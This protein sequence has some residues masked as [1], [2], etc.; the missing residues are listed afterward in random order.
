MLG[1]FDVIMSVEWCRENK[2]LTGT[3]RYASMNTHLGIGKCAACVDFVVIFLLLLLITNLYYYLRYR[4]KQEGWFG[5]SWICSSVLPKRKVIVAALCFYGCWW[6]VVSILTF[7]YCSLPWQG[8][9]TGNKRRKYGIISER[10][11]STSIEVIFANMI[12]IFLTCK[13]KWLIFIF[14][15]L[16]SRFSYRV[17]FISPVL[18]FTALWRQT[19]LCLSEENFQRPFYPQR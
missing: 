10:K 7:I 4:T 16:M 1:Y 12:T 15:G 3:A 2:N 14:T 9:K 5:I 8:I 17:C 18:S 11:M 19:R 13:R 6:I